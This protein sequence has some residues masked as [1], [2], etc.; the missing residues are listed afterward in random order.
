VKKLE[1]RLKTPSKKNEL[2]KVHFSSIGEGTKVFEIGT[3]RGVAEGLYIFD[4]IPRLAG[5]TFLVTEG[6]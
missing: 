5:R 2:R 1:G 3:F 6:L 4:S